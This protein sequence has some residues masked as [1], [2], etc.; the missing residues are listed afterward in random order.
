[1]KKFYTILL[2]ISLTSYLLTA[3]SVPGQVEFD[4]SG[5][6]YIEYIP[7]NL[8]IIISAPHGGLKLTGG[9]VNGVSYPDNNTTNNS[10]DPYYLPTRS[11]GTNERDD[12]TDVLIRRIQ[13]EIFQQTGGY[14]HIII[15]NLN[16]KKLDP[17]R[18]KSEATCGNTNAEFFWDAWHGFIDKASASVEANWGKGIYI[19]LHGQSH[20]VPRIEAGYNISAS[21]LNSSDL[22]S[23]AIINT[24]TIK[25]LEAIN[26]N[27]F[28]HE[29]L[30]R[31]EFSLGELFQNADGTFY[32]SNNYPGCTRNGTNGYRAVPSN[33]NYGNNTCDD[34]R[35]YSNAYFDGDYY[36]NRRH[37]SGNGAND[38]TG[39]GGT[40]D[41]IMTEVNRRVRDLGS[42]YDSRPNTLSPFA[43]DYAKVVLSFIDKHY[44]DFTEFNYNSNTYDKTDSNPTAILTNGVSGGEYTSSPAGLSIN[45]NTGEIDLNAS[46]IGNYEVTYSVGPLKSGDVAR[47]YNSPF[48]L[49]ITDTTLS[50]DYLETFAFT[51]F[52][53]PTK[54]IINFKSSKKISRIELYNILGKRINVFVINNSK[55]SIDL[56]KYNTGMYMA[57][58]YDE[59]EDKVI[60]KRIMKK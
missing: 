23:A 25:S 32:A 22:N 21:E 26:I 28:S 43:I 54:N 51:L 30:V 50:N 16:R 9:T 18:D 10:A 49:E 46:Q 48:S 35:P 34:T 60:M 5:K 11:C 42:P 38:G 41:G 53:N 20:S 8:P 57:S 58:F 36:N 7:G 27:S 59:N 40:V 56:T 13:D 1:M 44:N 45:A 4:E 52:P 37:G 14:A 12:N 55:G 24:S 2:T 17:N 33:S 19:D 39:G 47:Y 29:E 6:E 15:N 31:G 3:Q